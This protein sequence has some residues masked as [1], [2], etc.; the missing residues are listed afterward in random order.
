MRHYL[1]PFRY[2]DV[3]TITKGGFLIGTYGM[4]E[5]LV[6]FSNALRSL[7][8]EVFCDVPSGSDGVRVRMWKGKGKTWFYAVNS[9]GRPA[10]VRIRTGKASEITDTVSGAKKRIPESGFSL[11]LEPYSLRA[12][13]SFSIGELLLR[14]GNAFLYLVNGH[15]AL[16]AFILPVLDLLSAFKTI[17]CVR[18]LLTACQRS[19]D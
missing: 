17:H 16:R 18:L 7:P 1:V 15:T 3:A 2:F 19:G 8:N 4:E 12:S 13:N 5:Y 14:L 11:R 10:G 9:S 6:P